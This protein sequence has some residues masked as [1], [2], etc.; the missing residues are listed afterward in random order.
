MLLSSVVEPDPGSGI[1]E[2]N[3]FSIPK[4]RD[5]PGPNIR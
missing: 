3:S 5:Y 2:L 1:A 4:P